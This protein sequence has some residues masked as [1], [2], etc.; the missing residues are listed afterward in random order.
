MTFLALMMICASIAAWI[1]AGGAAPNAQFYIRLASIL[2]SAL[3]AAA[4][5]NASLANTTG[6]IAAAIGPVLLALAMFG[7]RPLSR[8][9]ASIAVAAA[10]ASGIA[11]AAMNMTVLAL[12]PLV[13][14][15]AAMAG[16]AIRG[17]RTGPARA[18]QAF[19]AALSFLTGACAYVNGGLIAQMALLLFSSVGLLGISLSLARDSDS[20]IEEQRRR[21]LHRSAIG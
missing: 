14:S 5:V 8:S 13:V 9:F 6:L 16:Y 15:V 1:L 10:A 19:A 12:A 3:G 17:W 21:D 18:V 4:A 2:F 11:A 20:A 7:A